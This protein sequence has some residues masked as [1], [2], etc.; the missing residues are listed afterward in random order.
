[1]F[2]EWVSFPR[3]RE[4]TCQVGEYARLK[5]QWFSGFRVKHGMTTVG[6][7]WRTECRMNPNAK[8]SAAFER[9]PI[10]SGM[11]FANIVF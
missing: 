4:S 7:T 5:L 10:L 1:M 8:N 2:A 6:D 9:V 11:I 3:N